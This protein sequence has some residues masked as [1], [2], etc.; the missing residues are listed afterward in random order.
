MPDHYEVE[1]ILQTRGK[2]KKKE[3][4][5]KFLGWPAK[6]NMWVGEDQISD[7]KK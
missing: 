4:L 5:I 3:Y 1:K 6:F 7:I 2:D